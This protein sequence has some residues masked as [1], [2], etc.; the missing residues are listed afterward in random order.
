[1]DLF[2]HRL[3]TF[4]VC[5]EW[6]HGDWDVSVVISE[7]CREVH[8]P[9]LTALGLEAASCSKADDQVW[10]ECLNCQKS[11]EGSWDGANIVYPMYLAF[12]CKA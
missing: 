4:I 2:A 6:P 8:V 10:L 1:M 9:Y 5:G 11:C 7:T 12:A 3:L